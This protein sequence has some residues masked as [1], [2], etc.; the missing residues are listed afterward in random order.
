[1]PA[2]AFLG[3]TL[4]YRELRGE[5]DRFATALAGLG[6]VKG[7]RVAIVLPNCPQN[8]ITFYA[9]LRLGAVVVQNNPL[10]TAAELGRQL[11]D[12]EPKVVVCLDKTYETVAAVRDEAKV[13][14]VVVTSIADYLPRQKRLAL[15]LPVKA[16]QQRKAEIT[17]T[18]PKDA[19]VRRFSK[20]LASAGTPAVQVPVDA[21]KDLALLQ[22]T[23][24]TTGASKGAMITH[25]NLVAN[26]YQIRLWMPEGVMGKEV[27]LGVLPLFHTYGLTLCMTTSMLFGGTLVLLPRFD[28]AEVFEAIGRWSPTLLPGVPPM[29]RAIVDA[30]QVSQYDLRSIRV[31][32]S[33][34]MRLDPELQERFERVTGGR[35]VE[36][37]GL[38]E[39]SPATHAN[40][41]TAERRSGTI[42]LPLPGTEVRVVDPDEP[43]REV[44]AGEVGEMV[45]RGP[46]VFAGYW[47]DPEGDRGGARPG[48]LAAHRRPRLD[49][50]RRLLHRGGPGQGRDRLGRAPRPPD[51]GGGRAAGAPRRRAG[52]RRRCPRPDARRD[53]QGVRGACGGC[54][55][56][57]VRACGALWR[58]PRRVQGAEAGRV[59]VVAAHQHG[60]Q[61]AAPPPGRDGRVAGG[62]E[63]VGGERVH[64]SA[65]ARGDPGR[66]D[67]RAARPARAR[68][69]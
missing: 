31:C 23:G 64:R 10:Y 63:R 65:D 20:L 37:Y 33:G 46:Q 40:P 1:M 13:E 44:G 18:L 34:A 17:A 49:G 36:G 32:I 3:T 48:G 12:A 67:R 69:G 57:R 28:L 27:T 41:L 62:A 30:P 42:G 47:R 24:G 4:T 25:A 8:V 22:Y 66:G 39:T 61:G 56:Q 9:T 19:P 5:V 43:A 59:P 14:H 11:A 38:T 50:R 7:D 2:L 51:R 29:Y 68:C 52:L 26:A 15:A 6:V 21:S 55:A 16:A 45:V 60:R 54:D 58:E 53:G 35:L